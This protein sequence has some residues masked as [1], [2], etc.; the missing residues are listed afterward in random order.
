MFESY[1]YGLHS[2]LPI[3]HLCKGTSVFMLTNSCQWKKERVVLMAI[4]FNVDI[5][6]ILVSSSG[7]GER[8]KGAK[9]FPS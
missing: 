2:I 1:I 3:K 8:G 4:R 5:E 7:K 9:P 6:L